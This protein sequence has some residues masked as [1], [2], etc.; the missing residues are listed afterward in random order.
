MG[1]GLL[2]LYSWLL[3]LFMLHIWKG[4][5][6]IGIGERLDVHIS[7][8]HGKGVAAQPH[9]R[10]SFIEFCLHPGIGVC[11]IDLIVDLVDH[12]CNK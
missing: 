3:V 1:F 12:S 4:N 11:L 8:A 10:L 2:C 7:A 6:E 9:P 5:R